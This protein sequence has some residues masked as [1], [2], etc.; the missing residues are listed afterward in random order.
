MADASRR[1]PASAT[2]SPS[3]W[4]RDVTLVTCPRDLLQRVACHTAAEKRPAQAYKAQN[5][6]HL[7]AGS[8]DSSTEQH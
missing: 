6:V 4:Q 1:V 7:P 5:G 2:P 3:L 8:H